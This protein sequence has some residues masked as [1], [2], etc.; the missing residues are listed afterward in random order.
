MAVDKRHT[1]LWVKV[2]IWVISLSFVFGGVV[3]VGFGGSSSPDTGDTGTTESDITAQ[4]KPAIDAAVAALA[5]DPENFDL[6]AYAGH[7]YFEWAVALYESGQQPA[8][9]PLWLA[10]VG[11]YDR[12][13]AIRPDDVVVLGNKGF[14]LAYANDQG[15]AAALRAFIAAD[16]NDTTGQV[17]NATELLASIEPQQSAPA[18]AS[19]L[20]TIP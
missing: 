9:V 5:A 10:A 15:A 6:L 17:A 18:T 20:T 8:A 11:Y 7:S 1:P 2:V 12:A 13:L 3:F 4:H 16:V 19:V 14:A